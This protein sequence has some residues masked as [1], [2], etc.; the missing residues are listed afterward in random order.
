ML[1]KKTFT[2]KYPR[3][4]RLHMMAPRY[5]RICFPV[6]TPDSESESSAGNVEVMKLIEEKKEL[7]V[8]TSSI[9]KMTKSQEK[10]LKKFKKKK[11]KFDKFM[12]NM[13]TVLKDYYLEYNSKS[14]S[15]NSPCWCTLS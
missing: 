11:E 5:P 3:W 12:D 2:K 13:E 14:K 7:E 15:D 9:G 8:I 6:V 10:C 4:C 1:L